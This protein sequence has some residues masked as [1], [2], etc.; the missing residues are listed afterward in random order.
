MKNYVQSA[1]DPSDWW[2]PYIYSLTRVFWEAETALRK[3]V[4]ASKQQG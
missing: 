3:E 1:T 4:G 2:L